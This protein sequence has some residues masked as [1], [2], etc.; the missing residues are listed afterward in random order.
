ME[1]DEYGV[2]LSLGGVIGEIPGWTK[3]W[4]SNKKTFSVN[5]ISANSS[6]VPPAVTSKT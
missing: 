2:V 1:R 6:T 4:R 5:L 3:K